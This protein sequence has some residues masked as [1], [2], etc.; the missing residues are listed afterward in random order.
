MLL[1][2]ASIACV[3]ILTA[4]ATRDTMSIAA[5]SSYS[6]ILL[7]VIVGGLSLI[8]GAL[9]VYTIAKA[10]ATQRKSTQEATH[11]RSQMETLDT[12]INSEPQVVLLWQQ[13]K[14]LKVVAHTLK[15]L[16]GLPQDEADIAEFQAWL[17][18]DSYQSLTDHLTR[19]SN[20]GEGFN[21]ILKTITGAH[22]EVDG[23]ASSGRAV[24]RIRDVMGHRKDLARLLDQ[25][26]N[27]AKDIATGQ[28]LLN[29]L[30]M[31]VWLRDMD[32]KL[33][34]VNQAYVDAVEA[35][36]IG[37]VLEGQ[38][39]LLEQRQRRDL[40]KTLGLGQRFNNRLAIN[41][42]GT[43]KNH[44]VVALKL[45]HA[46]AAAA[47][48]VAELESA[49][50]ELDR[51]IEAFDSTLH[52]VDTAIA[53]FDASHKLVFYNNAFQQ[54]WRIENEWLQAAP[55]IGNFLD[56]L[57]DSG[58][59]PEMG[60]YRDWRR[61]VIDAEGAKKDQDDYLHLPDGRVLHLIA[62]QR[63][64]GGITQLYVDETQ[65]IALESRV[66]ALSRVQGET[67]DNL[68]EGVAVF[69]TDGRLKLYN[70]AFTQIWH[71]SPQSLDGE[72]HIRAVIEQAQVLYDNVETWNDIL[73]AIT[74]FSDERQPT[75][76]QMIRPDN[77]V[78][79]Y[80][81]LPLPDGGTLLTFSDV[82]DAK[83]YERALEERNEALIASDRL[84]SQFIGHVSYQLRTPLT[85]IIGFSDF[86][87]EPL[88]G[89][90]NEKQHEY[91]NDIRTSSKTL[92][93]I[94]DDILDLTNLDAG[95]LELQVDTLA[96]KEIADSVIQGMSDRAA[97]KN[98][99][100]DLAIAEDAREFVGDAERIHQILENLISNAVGFSNEG[101]VVLVTCWR[102]EETVYLQV[103]D[104]GLGIS[105]DDQAHIFDRFFSK[106]KGSTHRGVGLGLSIV[107]SLVERH[108]GKMILKSR[109]GYGTQITVCLPEREGAIIGT[110]YSSELQ[111]AVEAIDAI[112]AEDFLN[113]SEPA[114][115]TDG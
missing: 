31:P 85:N 81:S 82:T 13:K 84:K 104:R 86:L 6:N 21:T 94:I 8:A 33:S 60:N 97:Q 112:E 47:I 70:T 89:E 54:L 7:F 75:R 87:A 105:N 88:L 29:N 19:L 4:A 27:L 9:V 26:A 68:T 43:R 25:H 64:D 38:I 49:R 36:S 76:G 108:G 50:G 46:T 99:V 114:T 101:G 11:L 113:S 18:R 57:Y 71:L 58:K 80:A 28:A 1:F 95:G 109:E 52:K 44:D 96:I 24:I 115:G 56:R 77:S 74:E 12:I 37:E 67:I 62:E 53:I 111:P 102:D 5:L 61:K 72:P 45:D 2:C 20:T 16:S 110:D 79:D 14:P 100:I 15:N 83:R 30:P 42:A 106:S 22:I 98:V 35:K 65:R 73:D 23:R 40:L 55:T 91:L 93:A 48:D 10:H 92:L 51:Q 3:L 107:K 63:P 32:S 66:N 69:A 78:I 103:E 59:L 17:D 34:W 90:L 39:E 41:I